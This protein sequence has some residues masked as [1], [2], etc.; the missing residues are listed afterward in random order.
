MATFYR[1]AIEKARAEFDKKVAVLAT[2]EPRKEIKDIA[3]RLGCSKFAIQISFR[4]QGISRA[5]VSGRRP[6]QVN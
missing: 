5:H 1:E 2:T 3:Q 4:R 6:K